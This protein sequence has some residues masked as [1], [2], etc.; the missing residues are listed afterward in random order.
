MLLQKLFLTS[1]FCVP[2]PPHVL[3]PR[4]RLKD[5]LTEGSADKLT[6]ISA[7]AGFGKTMLL[8]DWLSSQ[9]ESPRSVAWIT[10]DERDNDLR[11]FWECVLTALDACIP[12]LSQP[13]LVI[14]HGSHEFVLSDILHA[15]FV[16]LEKSDVA[17]V[18]LVLDNCQHLYEPA[19]YVSLITLLELLPPQL[20]LVLSTRQDPPLPLARLRGYGRLL[21][22]RG[23]E[24]RFTREEIRAFLSEVMELDLGEEV[25]QELTQRTEGWIVGVRLMAFALSHPD[26]VSLPASELVRGYE[27]TSYVREYFLKEVFQRQPQSIQ[28][29]LLRTAM[30]EQLSAPLCNELLELS[31]SQDIL[32]YLVKANVFLFPLHQQTGWY[33]YHPLW[34]QFLREMMEQNHGYLLPGL[35]HR[36]SAWYERQQDFARAIEYALRAEEWQRCATLIEQAGLPSTLPGYGIAN[37]TGWLQRLPVSVIQ[38][39][40]VLCLLY[41]YVLYLSDARSLAAGWLDEAESSLLVCQERLIAMGQQVISDPFQ[42]VQHLIGVQTVYRAYITLPDDAI[43]VLSLCQKARQ[44]LA[45]NDF[46]HRALVSLAESYVHY[47]YGEAE[48]AARS[49]FDAS[50]LALTAEHFPLLLVCVSSQA[51]YLMQQG[52]LGEAWRLLCQAVQNVEEGQAE[53]LATL[54]CVYI[55]QSC[56]LYEWNQLEVARQLVKQGIDALEQANISLFLE[57]GY[58]QLARICIATSQWQDASAALLQ[59]ERLMMRS[60]GAYYPGSLYVDLQIQICLACG[61]VRRAAYWSEKLLEH[62]VTHQ[63]YVQEHEDIGRVHVLLNLHRAE[64][65]LEL[66]DPLAAQASAQERRGD[67]LRILLLQVQAHQLLQQSDVASNIL[68]QALYIAQQ[69]NYLRC[70]IDFGEYIAPLIK[71]LANRSCG[72]L[73]FIDTVLK[74]FQSADIEVEVAHPTVE[75]VSLLSERELD[76]LRLLGNGVSNQEIGAR[77]M[78]TL[79]TVKGHVSSIFSKLDVSNRTQ[80]VV[81][82]QELGLLVLE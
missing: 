70:F 35:Y 53:N 23:E 4:F 10:V 21:E 45:E 7:P 80:A 37:V 49:A 19:I 14:L 46:A 51:M 24:L 13:A 62:R 48:K 54:G 74:A 12:G 82:A 65:A 66:L 6:L 73:P 31:D 29:F 64:E 52:Y 20:H 3:I 81:R 5:R 58:L 55:Q 67:L 71:S 68:E 43:A 8:C 38:A 75:I 61:E 60:N 11:R 33:R 30:L 77:L 63:V 42:R 32:S 2:V 27:K 57:K 44:L 39:R 16:A 34:A 18:T 1:K 36:V 78:V 41:A 56:I 50:I 40:P 69:E 15:L 17:N 28:I 9:K 47:Y 25:I 72:G 22:I 59:G 26:G 79:S 76:V